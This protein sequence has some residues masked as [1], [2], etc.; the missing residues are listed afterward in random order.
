M[1]LPFVLLDRSFLGVLSSS[2]LQCLKKGH[3]FAEVIAWRVPAF[4]AFDQA[5]LQ[6][7]KVAHWPH[8]FSEPC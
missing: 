2:S 5:P 1:A 6:V 4:V 7:L 8:V 3:S